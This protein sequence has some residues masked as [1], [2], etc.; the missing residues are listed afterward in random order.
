MTGDDDFNRCY[1]SC[2]VASGERDMEADTG[3]RN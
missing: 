3:Y 2:D 1:M